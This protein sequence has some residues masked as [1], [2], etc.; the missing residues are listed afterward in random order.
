MESKIHTD[1]ETKIVN[2]KVQHIRPLY[3]DLKQWTE[4]DNNIYIGRSR[5][6][7]IDGHRFPKKSSIWTN[8][9]KVENNRKESVLLPYEKYIRNKIENEYGVDELLKLKGK[10]LGCWCKPKSCH[11]DILIKLINEYSRK[12]EIQSKDQQY[13]EVQHY[14]PCCDEN[15]TETKCE[16]CEENIC[17]DCIIF[18]DN[19]NVK[20]CPVCITYDKYNKSNTLCESCYLN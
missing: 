5:I 3:T 19:C 20:C 2:I 13:Y 18:C 9:F 12:T 7:F 16:Y 6:V 11:G 8:P 15:Q 4:N 10:T 14:C 17:N 1:I